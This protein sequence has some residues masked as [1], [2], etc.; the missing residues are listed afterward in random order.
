M[1]YGSGCS[2]YEK[3]GCNSQN[4]M[5]GERKHITTPR[6]TKKEP[7]DGMTRESRRKS[8]SREIRYYFLIPG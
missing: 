8:S 3:E 4:S 7:K 6:F 1:E 5:N 2:Q